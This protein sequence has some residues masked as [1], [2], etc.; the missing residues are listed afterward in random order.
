MGDTIIAW[1]WISSDMKVSHRPRAPKFQI[2]K[3]KRLP[4]AKGRVDPKPVL[5]RTGFHA[6]L[7]LDDACTYG[8][9]TWLPRLALVELSGKMIGQTSVRDRSGDKLCATRIK[10]I[11]SVNM[12][13]FETRDGYDSNLANCDITPW[14][15]RRMRK[16]IRLEMIKQGLD[17]NLVPHR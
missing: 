3:W 10:I 6:S 5:C 2:G 15:R 8:Q 11:A 16:I 9:S 13:N 14:I 7:Y 17:P 4:E 12:S 1:K